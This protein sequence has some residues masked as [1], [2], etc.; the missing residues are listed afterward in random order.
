MRGAGGYW[1]GHPAWILG[2]L[3]LAHPAW[4]AP[5][6]RDAPS[7]ETGA[8]QWV[9]LYAGGAM[10]S[11][12]GDLGGD[13]AQSGFTVRHRMFLAHSL[14]PATLPTRYPQEPVKLDGGDSCGSRHMK[15]SKSWGD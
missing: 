13:Q 3:Q 15:Q 11:L 4:A 6:G 10:N 9:L 7:L 8:W 14:S 1:H 2:E 5:L 12:L